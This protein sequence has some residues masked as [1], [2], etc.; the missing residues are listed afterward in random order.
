[1]W[2]EYEGEGEQQ[3]ERQGNRT[4][5]REKGEERRQEAINWER[6]ERAWCC[7]VEID[8]FVAAQDYGLQ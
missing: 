5:G 2:A 1:M 4:R 6:G 3:R 7:Q 8:S